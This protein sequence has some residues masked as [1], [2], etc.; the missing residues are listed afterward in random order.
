LTWEARVP[1]TRRSWSDRVEV[2]FL[3][4]NGPDWVV[5][6]LKLSLL[7]DDSVLEWKV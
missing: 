6:I 1:K 5:R 7:K 2:S 3:W 4:I